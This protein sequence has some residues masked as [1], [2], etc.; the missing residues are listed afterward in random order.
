[1]TQL[2]KHLTVDFCLGHDLSQG[3]ESKPHSGSGGSLLEDSFHLS[4][5]APTPHSCSLLLYIH[6]IFKM[7]QRV[8]FRPHVSMSLEGETPHRVCN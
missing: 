5:S 3:R 8:V 7:P 6:E 4:L 2:I 1:M